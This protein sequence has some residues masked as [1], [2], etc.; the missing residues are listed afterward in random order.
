MGV[1]GMNEDKPV[2]LIEVQPEVTE[3]EPIEQV[4]S[5]EPEDVRIVEP[6]TESEDREMFEETAR[7]EEEIDAP[8]VEHKPERKKAMKSKVTRKSPAR[9]QSE[10]KPISQFQNEL[11][12]HSD[13][14][15]KAEREILDIRKELKDL[16]L[17]H[18]ASIKDL[19]KQMTQM[20]KKIT[21]IENSRKTT[22]VNAKKTSAGKKTSSS[23][24]SKKKSGQKKSGKRQ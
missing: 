13:A 1:E 18:H 10:G 9:I 4:F 6:S 15:K 23:K 3:E 16:L 7:F 20:H 14:R 12:K 19:Q 11:R 8:K 17:V 24:K 2:S 21:T 22:N 5:E